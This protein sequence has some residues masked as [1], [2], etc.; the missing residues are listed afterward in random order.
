MAGAPATIGVQEGATVRWP[1]SRARPML[2]VSG[3]LSKVEQTL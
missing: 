1:I 3:E 2:P